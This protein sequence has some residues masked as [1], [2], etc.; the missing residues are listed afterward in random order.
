VTNLFL[1]RRTMR[2]ELLERESRHGSGNCGLFA[3][4]M[5]FSSFNALPRHKL[6]SYHIK[7]EDEGSY[8]NDDIRCFILSN[9]ATARMAHAYCLVCQ[10]A[11]TIYD[12]YPLIDGTFFL[13]PKQYSKAC[14]PVTVEGRQQYLSSVCMACLEGWTCSLRC[15]SCRTRWD[16]SALILGTLYSYDV[17][18][19]VPCCPDRLRCNNCS[20]LVVTPEHRFPFFSQYSREM[21]CPNCSSTQPHFVKPLPAVFQLFPT[22]PH[23]PGC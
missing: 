4:R 23:S 6:N 16:G 22:P 15:R 11:M 18:A 19:A 14:I 2:T 3:H 8:G 12:R 20:G 5:D 1:K 10:N 7:M 13:S 21:S 17:F 9:L